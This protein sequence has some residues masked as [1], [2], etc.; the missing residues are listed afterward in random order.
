MNFSIW[1]NE[2]LVGLAVAQ[3]I[4]DKYRLYKPTFKTKQTR[5]KI[6]QK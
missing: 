4:E 2:L 3:L 1:K 6:K 5:N